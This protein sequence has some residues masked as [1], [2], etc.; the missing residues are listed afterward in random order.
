TPTTA[1]DACRCCDGALQGWQGPR[2]W[3]RHARQGGLGVDQ[4]AVSQE[5]RGEEGR[6]AGSAQPWAWAQGRRASA[7]V[8]QGSS[9]PRHRMGWGQSYVGDLVR[10]SA[11]GVLTT[12]CRRFATK[13]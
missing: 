6:Q 7:T 12:V 11:C 13:P 8:R 2:Q 4:E 3:P 1:V 10:T 9:S 5:D